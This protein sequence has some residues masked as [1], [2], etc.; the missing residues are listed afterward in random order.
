MIRFQ[1]LLV[2]TLIVIPAVALMTA[3]GIWQ[4]QRLEWKSGLVVAVEAR[5]HA[6]PVPLADVLKLS[7]EEA[8]YRIVRVMGRF[9]HDKEAYLFTTG[10]DG[11]PGAHVITPLEQADGTFVLVDRGFVP[12]DRQ[13]PGSR[14]DGRIPGETTVTGML[15]AGQHG[16]MFTPKPD[17]THRVWFVRDAAQISAALGISTV[18][19]VLIDADATANPGGL[20]LGGQTMVAFPNNHLSYAWTWF[21][22][23]LTLVAVYL[24]YHHSKQRLRFR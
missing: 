17:L 15:R 12:A 11:Q 21:G 2:P 19:P 8:E 7:P 5:V 18:A 1:P 6:D 20:P 4:L 10:P 16:G 3:L 13:D 23:A 24:I 14:A 22:L 9:H